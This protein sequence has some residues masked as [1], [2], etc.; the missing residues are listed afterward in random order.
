VRG[1]PVVVEVHLLSAHDDGLRYRT[2][3]GSTDGGHPNQIAAQ[4]AGFD[5]PR[6][7]DADGLVLSCPNAA[8]ISSR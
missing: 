5:A 4:L 7:D 8:D 1:S 3:S 6:L 2:L